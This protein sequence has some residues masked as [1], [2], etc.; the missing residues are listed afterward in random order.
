MGYPL[1]PENGSSHR[2]RTKCNRELIIC[3]FTLSQVRSMHEVS[4]RAKIHKLRKYEGISATE[5]AR[6]AK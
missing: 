1:G 4:L 3:T 5:A 6:E 2:S